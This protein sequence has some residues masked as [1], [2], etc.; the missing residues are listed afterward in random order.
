[1]LEK[2]KEK[3]WKNE[4]KKISEKAQKNSFLGVCEE[5]W[6]FFVKMSFLEK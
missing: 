5:N 3:T 4:K 2:E 6:S 1:M